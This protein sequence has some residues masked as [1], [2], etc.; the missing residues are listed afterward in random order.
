[1]PIAEHSG[2]GP[3]HYCRSVRPGDADGL[4]F[5]R[6]GADVI[7]WGWRDWRKWR[8]NVTD[9]ELG[10]FTVYRL[11][12]TW[13]WSWIGALIWP[14]GRAYHIWFHYRLGLEA[15]RTMCP[16]CVQRILHQ[17]GSD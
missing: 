12:R 14:M 6:F 9:I 10:P 8:W 11:K 2:S 3:C 4:F 5:R 17:K 15:A 13:F 16:G 7:W 1:M